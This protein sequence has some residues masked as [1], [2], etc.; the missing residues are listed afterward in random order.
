M[1]KVPANGDDDDDGDKDDDDDFVDGDA[2]RGQERRSPVGDGE[3]RRKDRAPGT[4]VTRRAAAAAG[5]LKSMLLF[6][7]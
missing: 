6:L 2:E 3:A 5:T 7:V 1:E 4:A